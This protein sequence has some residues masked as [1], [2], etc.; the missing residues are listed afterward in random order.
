MSRTYLLLLL[1]VLAG[2]LLLPVPLL[3]D[4]HFE[5]AMIVAV[6]GAYWSAISGARA[7]AKNDFFE[8]LKILGYGYLLGLP[9]FIFSAFSGCLS[10]HGI[11]FWIF[12]PFPSIFLGRAIGR[13]IREFSLPLSK[14]LA[15][16][17][18]S[19]IALGIWL[20]EFFTL[21]QVYFFNH[22]W[23]TWPGP[24]YDETVQLTGAFVFFRWITLLWIILLWMLPD[25][26]SSIQNKLITAFAIFALMFSYLNMS[27]M[28]IITPRDALK[29]QL[30][31]HKHTQHFNLYFDNEHFTSEEADYWALRHEFHFKQ[32]VELLEIDWPENQKIESYLYANAWQKKRLV[33][34]KFTSY[35]PIW[36]EQDQLHI[37][38]QQLDGVLKHEM[39]H[40]ISKQFGNW[41][42]NGS[43]SIGMIEG[44][45][46]AIAA[47][48]S[49]QST[50][51]QIM[52]ADTPY[53]STQQMQK[54][55]S[56]TGF[57]GDAAAI[58][59]TTAGAF[60]QFLL[61]NYPVESF[62][63][64]YPNNDFRQAYEVPFDALVSKWIQTLP[65]VKI[66]S[67][68]R[69]I[70]E[71]IFS[72]QSLF[73]RSCPHLLSPSLHLWDEFQY[74]NTIDD[75]TSALAAISS[76]FEMDTT[77]LLVKRD[78]ASSLLHNGLYQ[79]VFQKISDQ[80][81]ALT[82]QL[83]KADALFLSG[84]I[85]EAQELLQILKPRLD[86][87]TARNFLYSYSLREDV[88]QWNA[89]VSRRYKNQLPSLPDFETLNEA[90]QVLSAAIA[91]ELYEDSL[92]RNYSGSL[93]ESQLNP[94]W[95]DIYES[96]IDRLIFIE[97]FDLAEQWIT[98]LSEINL[99]DRYRERLNELAEWKAFLD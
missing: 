36:L 80:D 67:L 31:M 37:A 50:L 14:T 8:A 63:K 12:I 85:S 90:N 92:L 99:R 91:L 15:I 38:K 45:A 62:K 5:S 30:S 32:I 16:I 24:I 56:N 94:D 66:D 20:V 60:V 21:P 40:A 69:Q 25:W 29:E 54:A 96:I 39:V 73:Q 28:G 41:L 44:L 51:Q 93:I 33:G 88:N 18:I 55:F 3:R 10:I 23:G 13:L 95:F 42:F 48:A 26:N 81:S 64:A 52:A 7:H 97:Q 76:L 35:V 72:Q 11:G 83:L 27:E 65:P 71:F 86:K 77:N 59:Y 61:E 22:I 82:L 84:N 57:Y 78:W 74:F 89:H 46:E 6:I 9:V 53:P 17:V 43:W 4:F 34:A 98:K 87:T 79:P 75:S 49:S 68:D 2:L 70:S 19:M 47:D 1:P 58:S